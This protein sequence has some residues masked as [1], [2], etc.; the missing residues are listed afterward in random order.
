MA[1][2][3][4]TRRLKQ[5]TIAKRPRPPTLDRHASR[6]ATALGR[7]MDPLLAIVLSHVLPLTSPDFVRQDAADLE[8]IVQAF[9]RLRVGVFQRLITA[10]GLDARRTANGVEQQNKRETRRVLG[11]DV[12]Q[13]EPYLQPLVNDWV[14]E[15]VALVRSVAEQGLGDLEKTILR[16]VRDGE[17]TRAVRKE[18]VEAFDLSKNR[19][20]LLA[21]DQVSK[22]NGQLT[23]ER[24]TRLG[25]TE[26]IWHTV[27]DQRVRPDHDKLD[28]KRFKWASPPVTV[29]TGRRS[30]ERNNPGGDIQC[31]CWAEPVLD[32]L[33]AA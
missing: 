30:G 26:Y 21:R 19:A 32:K 18:L 11:V 5:R 29:R 16:M 33:R 7:H 13:T 25:V 4:T 23:E 3:A 31:R 20:K 28:D 10:V 15:N 14:S 2:T 24:Q 17:S 22:L 9:G 12:L 27:E 1:T 8:T 6:Y